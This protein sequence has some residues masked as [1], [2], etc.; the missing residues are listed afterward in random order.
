MA[1]ENENR[2]HAAINLRFIQPAAAGPLQ[3]VASSG[4]DL[5]S[6]QTIEDGVYLLRLSEGISDA[7]LAIALAPGAQAGGANLVQIAGCVR[8][9]VSGLPADPEQRTF[10]IVT[11]DNGPT[12]IVGEISV[13]WFRI[14][15]PGPPIPLP[16]PPPPPP[17]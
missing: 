5:D 14:A 17:P 8:P 16:A 11:Q 15:Q 9:Q 1:Q 10:V 12:N 3:I 4:I 13:L 6:V 2:V 7:E